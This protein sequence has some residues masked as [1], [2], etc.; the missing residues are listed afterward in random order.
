MVK[1]FLTRVSRQFNG[2]RI[3]F[4]TNDVGSTRYPYEKGRKEGRKEN[5]LPPYH[6]P[7]TEINT[8]W[9]LDVSGRVKTIKNFRRKHNYKSL[10]FWI[11]QWF[12]RYD[13]KIISSKIKNR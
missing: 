11:E 12:I 1:W 9:V 13:T 5:K 7:Y 6:I 3:I 2:E 4:L 8:K 10:W